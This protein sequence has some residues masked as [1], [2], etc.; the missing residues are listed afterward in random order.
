MCAGES[1]RGQDSQP[2]ARHVDEV[3]QRLHIAWMYMNVCML[4][5]AYRYIHAHAY[6]HAHAHTHGVH[7]NIMLV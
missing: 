4:H 5:T 2:L 1:T 7:L 6:A 3:V